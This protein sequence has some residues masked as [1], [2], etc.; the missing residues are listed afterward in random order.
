MQDR[1]TEYRNVKNRKKDKN[2]TMQ[3]IFLCFLLKS[4]GKTYTYLKDFFS[5]SVR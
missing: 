5:S 1:E 2:K 3:P 4:F